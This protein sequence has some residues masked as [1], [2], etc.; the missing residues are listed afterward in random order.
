MDTK[1]FK[2]LALRVRKK[3]FLLTFMLAESS[4]TLVH[5]VH[6][7]TALDPQGYSI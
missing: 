6:R 2:A 7:Y 1:M 5:V 3:S 4:V